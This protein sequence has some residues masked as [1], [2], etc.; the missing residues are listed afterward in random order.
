LE[1]FFG[2]TKNALN[3]NQEDVI[4]F[5]TTLRDLGGWDSLGKFM[6]VSSL[7][8]EYGVV[9]DPE[10]VNNAATVGDIWRLV[11]SSLEPDG[12]N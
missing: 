10:K 7:F 1:K 3:M 11:E 12:G 2:I 9:M 5:E 4:G 6:L 8:S